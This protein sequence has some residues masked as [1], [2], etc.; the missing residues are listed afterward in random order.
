MDTNIT[1]NPGVK[2]LPIRGINFNALKV[3]KVT[4]KIVKTVD[5]FADAKVNLENV[6]I[7]CSIHYEVKTRFKVKVIGLFPKM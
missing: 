6:F 3:W 7:V 1:T 5:D 2:C 4:C